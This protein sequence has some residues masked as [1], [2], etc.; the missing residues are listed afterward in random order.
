MALQIQ[1]TLCR[2]VRTFVF[3]SC[4]CSRPSLGNKASSVS[5]TLL[6]AEWGN[7]TSYGMKN[8]DQNP[9]DMMTECDR[10]I[11]TAIS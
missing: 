11:L 10:V 6:D 9:R 7:A 1:L 8:A 4:H 3:G 5:E 2:Y